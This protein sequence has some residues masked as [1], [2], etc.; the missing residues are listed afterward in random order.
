MKRGEAIGPILREWMQ[1]S[2]AVSSAS[3]PAIGAWTRLYSTAVPGSQGLL[4]PGARAWPE[5]AW[6]AVANLTITE[7]QTAVD[8]SLAR[9]DGDD[10]L[11]EGPPSERISA[12]RS[13]I[14][15]IG[16]SQKKRPRKSPS[17]SQATSNQS[18]PLN[19]AEIADLANIS[20][21]AT[22]K[23]KFS[24]GGGGV[25]H[26]QS[27]SAVDPNQTGSGS[28]L[29]SAS[30]SAPA[31]PPKL[32]LVKD[33]PT[34]FDAF[35]SAYPRKVARAAAMKAWTKQKPILSKVLVALEWQSKTDGWQK[36]AG[37]F[38][39][40]PASWL[41][42]RRWEDAREVTP[43]SMS[44]AAAA[45]AKSPG[46]TLADLSIADQEK[47]AA[48]RKVNGYQDDAYYFKLLG[49]RA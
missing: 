30:A 27:R 17:K 4:I 28:T 1:S 16:G 49:I 3:V 43:G 44:S 22:S 41:N 7:M 21:I 8:A 33:Q 9:W 12:L 11:L 6:I 38:I 15:R 34:A 2:H 18:T 19:S 13:F 14:G 42:G 25:D 48:D 26:V 35:W 5:R 20:G 24:K 45:A 29:A 39:P 23:Q 31:T 47:I 32:A 46:A 36:D 40:H 37:Q 10:L